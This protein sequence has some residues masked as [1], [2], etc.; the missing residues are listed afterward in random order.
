MKNSEL[1]FTD[2]NEVKERLGID[3]ELFWE[4]ICVFAQDVKN[5]MELI[6]KAY[7]ECDIET[8][9]SN[10]HGIKGA[11]ANVGAY[12]LSS[13]CTE[14]EGKIKEQG[15]D[16]IYR[17]INEFVCHVTEVMKEIDDKSID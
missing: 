4:I 16:G 7:E 9:V 8:F 12:E 11:S 14:F 1:K 2:S 5:R 10:V 15:M 3:D 13:L 6:S 17:Y